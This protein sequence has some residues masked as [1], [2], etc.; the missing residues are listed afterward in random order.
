MNATHQ[1][2]EH[3]EGQ[4]E[5]LYGELIEHVLDRGGYLIQSPR[6]FVAYY[7]EDGVAHVLYACGSMKELLRFARDNAASMGV[8]HIGWERS[9]VGKHK[10]Y[11]IYSMDK[12]CRKR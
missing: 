8:E 1:A 3:L 4:H 10:S 12:L 9:L 11:N 2:Y 7:V 5:G 6:Y